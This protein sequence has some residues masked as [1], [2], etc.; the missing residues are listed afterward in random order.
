MAST[1][2]NAIAAPFVTAEKLRESQEFEQRRTGVKDEHK[3]EVV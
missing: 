3:R 1:K 2:I